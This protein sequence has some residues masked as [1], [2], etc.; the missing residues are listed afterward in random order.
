MSAAAAQG[1]RAVVAPLHLVERVQQ[2]VQ[3]IGLDGE[4]VPAVFVADLRVV[5]ADLQREGDGGGGLL[6]GAFGGL[7]GVCGGRHQYFLSIGT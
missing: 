1:Q 2:P 5:A 7:Q 6:L 4:L 3:R